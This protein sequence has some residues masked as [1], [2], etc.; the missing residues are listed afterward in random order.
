MRFSSSVDRS[1]RCPERL[2]PERRA[3]RPATITAWRLDGAIRFLRGIA[4]RR[5]GRKAA[6]KRATCCGVRSFFLDQ[7]IVSLMP[8]KLAP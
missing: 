1:L 5:P 6:A 2:E 8:S 3:W 7:R 4:G